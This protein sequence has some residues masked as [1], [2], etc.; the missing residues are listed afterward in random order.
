MKS[1]ALPNVCVSLTA[2]ST[3]ETIRKLRMFKL[4]EIRLDGMKLKREEVREIFSLR[5]QLIATCRPG[6]MTEKGRA[7]LLVE[8][9]DAGASYVDVEIESRKWYRELIVS[10]AREKG[11]K[12]IISYH[13]YEETPSDSALNKVIEKARR[14]GGDI[15][16]IACEANSLSDSA[17]LLGL[18]GHQSGLIVIG[19][20]KLGRITRVVAP[21]LGAPFTFASLSDG[22]ET[23]EGQMDFGKTL[24]IIGA[25]M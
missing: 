2:L 11:C 22:K 7:E 8:A 17:R 16:K 25:L 23:A 4:A 3:P 13:N 18:L 21:I 24:E 14:Y 20:G 6:N 1:S 12:V 19:M 9:I 5:L 10:K 15:I